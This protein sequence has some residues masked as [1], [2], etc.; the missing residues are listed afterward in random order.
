MNVE[1]S[2]RE[3]EHLAELLH[4]LVVVVWEVEEELPLEEE[5]I[6]IV[7]RMTLVYHRSYCHG[8]SRLVHLSDLVCFLREMDW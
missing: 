7:R 1:D 3:M 8:C 6:S 2:R 4:E 5:E